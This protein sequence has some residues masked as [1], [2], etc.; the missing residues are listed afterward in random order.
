M[1]NRL[2]NAPVLALDIDGTT[3][4]Y[5]GHFTRFAEMYIGRTLSPDWKP[6]YKGKF[7]K[8]LGISKTKYR[9]CKLA[10]RQGGMKRSMPV[11]LGAHELTVSMRKAGVQI[12]ICTTRPYL[13]L[14]NIDPDTRHFFRRNGIQFDGVIYGERKYQDLVKIVGTHRVIGVLDDLPEQ[15]ESATRLGL[16]AV[17]RSG[18]HNEWW[19]VDHPDQQCVA[20]LYDAHRIFKKMLADW[21]ES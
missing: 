7:H 20:T 17:M 16:P 18:P 1:P 2:P 6:E 4:D 14:D 5:H 12:W 19:R 11:F 13:R 8:A 10:Y 21:R 9:E 3:G 15:I